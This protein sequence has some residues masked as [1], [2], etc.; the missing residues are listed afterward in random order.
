MPLIPGQRV[1]PYEVVAAIGEGGMGQVYRARDT[2]LGR[3]VALKILP[4]L[5]A[6]DPERVARFQ[7]EAHVL[8]SLS[9]P[10]IA[11]VHGLEEIVSTGAGPPAQALVMELVEGPT[12]ADRIAEGPLP[13]DDA[14][15]IG[16]Q[17]GSALDG[18]HGQGIVHRDLKPANI[19]VR[20]D[21]TVKV[22]DFGLAKAITGADSSPAAVMN[23]PTLTA[24]ATELGVILGTAA[25]MSP[26]QARGRSVDKR[27]DIWAFGCVLLEMLTG[28][29]AFAGEDATETLASV[30]KGE[31]DI[32]RAPASVRR[33][34]K[35][36]LEK[37]PKRRLRDIGDVWDLLDVEPRHVS[38]FEA[39][40]SAGRRPLV[41]WIVSAS[42]VAALA[43]LAV[44]HFREARAASPSTT[45]FDV[46]WPVT[47][48]S[49]ALGGTRFFQLSPDGRTLLVG[50]HEGLWVRPLESVEATRLDRT[51]GAL[52]PFWSPDSH[53]IAFFQGGQLKTIPRSGG[54]VR[55]LC[56]AP[57]PRGGTWGSR[58]TIVFSSGFGQ[59][60]LMRIGEQGGAPVPVTT[61]ETANVG[62]A[63][64]YPQF[65]P[66]GER[67][68]YLYLSGKPDTSG[69]Y[70]GSPGGTPVR[71]LEGQDSALVVEG[72]KSTGG[73]YLLYR[74]QGT[75]MASA[76]DMDRLTTTGSPFV[77]AADVGQGENTGLGAFSVA[78]DGTLAFRTNYDAPR[79]V[80]WLDRAGMPVRVVASGLNVSDL[81][82]SDNDEKIAISIAARGTN[83]DVWLL[84]GGGGAPSRFTFGPPPGWLFPV[85]S[86]QGDA[87]AYATFDLAGLAGY[88]IRRKSSSGAGA[89]E[90]IY[91]SSG[92]LWLWDWSPDGKFLVFS[93]GDVL[94]ALP[95][96]GD[97]TP[98]ALTKVS[99]EGQYGQVSPN[100]RW[101]AY[102][103]LERGQTEIL[104]QPLPPTGALWQIS[105]GGG[106]APRWRRDGRELYYRAADGRLTAVGLAEGPDGSIQAGSAQAL[107]PIPSMG[108]IERYVY[109]PAADGQ[110]VLVSRP[111][112]G[113]ETPITVVLNW[114][115][116]VNT[117]RR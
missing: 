31:P 95:L 29:R 101:L 71:V 30:V 115:A 61:L 59:Q 22:L 99:A 72:G 89:E 86:P 27:A 3:D 11:I 41:P 42:A 53:Q 76:F 57:E 14:L 47:R 19:K 46:A 43:T 32:S 6:H 94:N 28:T 90:T 33:L 98:T 105:Q 74:R 51:Q 55:T 83:S 79:E 4:E 2:K 44:V 104:V 16:R 60:G 9:D 21:G 106:T 97:R 78:R 13:L 24:R 80:V 113:A 88:E 100:G 45:R 116:A 84:P 82:L 48:G 39:R 117:E 12:L 96:D 7:R 25:Y 110:R 81:A 103:A 23:S 38:A 15:A 109:A 93:D 20:P 40:S 91:R 18:A 37:D 17:I 70:V 63:H 107:F 10:N 75:L 1:G 67:F 64:R 66:D 85:W 108:N 49:S 34:L 50:T 36:C 5:F 73:A 111:I 58:G 68:L 65:L 35:K 56:P 52:Y 54:T 112:A 62:T 114:S 92:V 102:A 8:A 87:I 77:V 69:V 26:E